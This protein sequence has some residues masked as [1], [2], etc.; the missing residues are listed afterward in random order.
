MNEMP[1]FHAQADAL[2]FETRAFIGGRY[3]A[4]ASGER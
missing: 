4:A 1:N 2:K 3:V